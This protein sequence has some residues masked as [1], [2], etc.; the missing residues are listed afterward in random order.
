MR[1]APGRSHDHDGIVHSTEPSDGLTAPPGPAAVST[2]ASSPRG[3]VD[4]FVPLRRNGLDPV[5]ELARLRESEPV[6][7]VEFPFG[8]GAW[9]VSGY[10]TVRA[11]LGDAAAFSNDFG[12]LAGAL[13]GAAPARQNPGGLGMS[14]PPEHTRL[15]KFLTPEFTVRRLR[16]LIPHIAEITGSL[17]DAMAASGPPVDIVERFA[18]P[19]PS[20]VICELLGV[21]YPDRAAFAKLSGAR[22]DIFGGAGTGLDAISESL[23]Y[24]RELVTEQRRR[25]GDGLL[26][27]LIRQH[28]DE[29]DDAELAGLADGV[30]IGGHETTAS[31]LALGTLALLR[32]G[33]GASLM[34]RGDTTQV[35]DAVEELLRY[36]SVVQV[37]FPRFARADIVIDGQQIRAGDLVLCSLAGA[38]RD[39]ALGDGVEGLDLSGSPRQHLAF[40]HGV[41]RC[42]GSELARME[43]RIALP[44]L[45]GRFP[46]LHLDGRWSD[47]R[48]REYS[49][50]YG[51]ETVAVAW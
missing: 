44:A 24:M 25:P 34:R 27:M 35:H 42:I 31:M 7:R 29:I 28:G 23:R 18:T 51:V 39:A 8:I 32:S 15:R 43:L 47:V 6:C 10:D 40:G 16:R 17:L 33:E 41:H 30:L 19:L 49:V 2:S 46:A 3:A 50:V 20:L 21:P 14:D 12:R 36:L 38:N 11:V 4:P 9:I 5:P 1:S 37:A 26:G 45:F 13:Q 48:F 22:F